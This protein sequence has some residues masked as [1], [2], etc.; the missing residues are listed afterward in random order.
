MNL[1]HPIRN[2][3]AI[4]VAKVHADAA[5]EIAHIHADAAAERKALSAELRAALTKARADLVVVTESPEVRADVDKALR[6]VL[7]AL[8]T[9][10]L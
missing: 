2:A 9:H 7:T 6:Y 8:V 10:G 4:A 3:V 1:L 5:V